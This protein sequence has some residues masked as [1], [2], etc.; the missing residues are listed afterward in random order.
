MDDPVAAILLCVVLPL[1]FGAGIA[2]WLCHRATVI[3]R[4]SGFRESLLHLLQFAEIGAALVVVLFC[5]VNA[6]VFAIA[7]TALVL[8]EATAIWDV[9]YAARHRRVLPVEQHVHA[10]LE[11]LPL[12]A[13]LLLAVAHWP[14]FLA[15]FGL[16]PEPARFELAWK[17]PPLPADLILAI[18]GA[19]FLLEFL[20]YAEELW[21][22]WRAR[23]AP[24][25]EP[26]AK[27]RRGH[28]PTREASSVR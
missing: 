15:L 23:H 16:G 14:Q 7:L 12:A 8:H 19:A 11:I 2:D 25:R 6:L 13:I 9:R 28:P 10:V 17:R 24:R 20:P 27:D 4:T 18:L 3:E 21:R 5:E 26:D 22:G 1:W